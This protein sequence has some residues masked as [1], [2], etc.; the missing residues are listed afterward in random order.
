MQQVDF[1]RFKSLMNGMAKL[2]E[3]ELDTAMLDAYWLALQDWELEH[4]E[5]AV[6]QLLRTSKFMP[7]PSEFHDLRKAGR[8]TA[9]EAWAQV[10]KYVRTDYSPSGLP[11][12]NGRVAPRFSPETKRAVE[13]IGGFRTIAFSEISQTPFLEKRFCEHF[14]AIQDAVEVREAVPQITTDTRPQISGPRK[15]LS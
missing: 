10:L 13:A 9:G 2:Y 5:A 12:L 11:C 4:F 8:Q 14:E 6:V 7:R 1:Q 15:L 3:R